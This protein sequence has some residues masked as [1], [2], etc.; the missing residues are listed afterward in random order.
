M[1]N[2]SITYEGPPVQRQVVKATAMAPLSSLLAEACA[3]MKPPLDPAHATL[4]C[5]KKPL[6]D[7]SCPFR[8]ANIPNGSRLTLLYSQPARGASPE[9]IAAAAGGPAASAANPAQPAP[10]RQSQPPSPPAAAAVRGPAASNPPPC[11]PAVA[12]PAN[13]AN[14]A[15]ASDDG[16]ALGLTSEQGQKQQQTCDVEMLPTAAAPQPSAKEAASDTAVPAPLQPMDLDVA[17]ANTSA[18]TTTTPP[19]NTGNDAAGSSG[20]G[21]TAAAA[22]STTVADGGSIVEGSEADHLGLGRASA[23][24]S[25]EALE[26]AQGLLAAAARSAYGS[27]GTSSSGDGGDTGGAGDAAEGEDFFEVTQEDLASMMR[28]SQVRRMQQEEAAGFRTRAA[29]E[30][31]DRAKALLYSH[32]AIRAH[33]PGDLILQVTFAATES[34]GALRLAVLS[35]LSPSLAPAVYLYTTPPR[36][37]L[38]PDQDHHS[39]YQAGLVPAAHVHVGLDAKKAA[40]AGHTAG[41]SV[42]R[43]EMAARVRSRIG[44]ELAAFHASR[45]AQAPAEERKQQGTQKED[46]VGARA[47]VAGGAAGRGATTAGGS[48]GGGAKVPKWLQLGTK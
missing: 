8:L 28:S 23:M 27:T 18:A 25:R 33:L 14:T 35:V 19:N 2:I 45:P 9:R 1:A 15:D 40:A 47:A 34:I 11:T 24:F 13:T 36:Q 12:A 21:A 41:A 22:I 3:K 39:L 30:A 7:L 20:G 29:R 10:S 16:S 6:T 44:P 37:V 43:P 32:V 26:A 46:P 5:N 4:I 48:N 31:E 38:Y 42:L 17:A